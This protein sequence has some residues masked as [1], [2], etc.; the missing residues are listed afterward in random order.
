V[1]GILARV[2]R[3]LAALARGHVRRCGCPACDPAEREAR[4]AIGMSARHP[5]RITRDLPGGQEEW[6]AML[7]ALLWPEDEYTTI[8]TE[9]R[10][11]DRP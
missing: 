7:A 8:I 5:E 2:L 3:R 4:T 9:L 10:R 6:L 11:D 1:T